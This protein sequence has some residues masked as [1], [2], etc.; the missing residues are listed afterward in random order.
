[1]RCDS[2]VSARTE[3]RWLSWLAQL[4]TT[5][6]PGGQVSS[7]V[8]AMRILACK[9]RTTRGRHQHLCETSHASVWRVLLMATARTS[10]PLSTARGAW[11]WRVTLRSYDCQAGCLSPL[12]APL[13]SSS[14][15]QPQRTSHRRHNST[16]SAACSVPLHALIW[17]GHASAWRGVA[18]MLPARSPPDG[19]CGVSG[20]HKPGPRGRCRVLPTGTLQS[21]LHQRLGRMPRL[22]HYYSRLCCRLVHSSRPSQCT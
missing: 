20:L 21:T 15:P 17:P 16:A 18:A 1:M 10:R 5:S 22:S 7:K 8:T 2:W 9:L 14:P 6:Q 19:G 11:S 4:G 13:R 12:A 3:R